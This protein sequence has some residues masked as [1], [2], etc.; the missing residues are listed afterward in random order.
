M[1][2][3]VQM[4]LPFILLL[5]KWSGVG[6]TE[7]RGKFGGSVASKGRGGAY[8]RNKVTPVN[9]RSPFQQV[10][11]STLAF[12]SQAYRAL[13]VDQ[14]AAW[15]TAAGAGYVTTNIF[16]DTVKKSGIGL[17]TALNMN[18]RTIGESPISN[19]PVQGS[20]GNMVGIAPTAADVANTIF[21]VGENFT[22]GT[23]VDAGN[24]LVVLASPPVSRGVSFIKSQL[25]I[26][27]T[28]AAGANTTTT[29]LHTMYT[30]RF[31]SPVAG[32]KIFLGCNAVNLTTGQAGVPIV[33]SLIV[34]A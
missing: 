23:T 33:T 34:A 27:G 8:V 11:R 19:P 5:V 32:Q 31:G 26:I 7:G 9:P 1:K 20:V 30:V 6:M 2:K 28:I 18:L 25:R 29:N 14:I 21:L 17:Y 4:I 15:N 22:G 3:T 24:T 10:I 16:G 12:F 13:S